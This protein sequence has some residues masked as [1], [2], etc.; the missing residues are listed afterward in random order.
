MANDVLQFSDKIGV[1]TTN[2]SFVSSNIFQNHMANVRF[3]KETSIHLCF[4]VKTKKFVFLIRYKILSEMNKSNRHSFVYIS[5]FS[6]T[7]L[8]VVIHA[9]HNC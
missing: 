9:P 7:I 6:I 4:P 1:F 3:N 5:R 8:L 2:K